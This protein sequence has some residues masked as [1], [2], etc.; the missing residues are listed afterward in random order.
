MSSGG[1]VECTGWS[2]GV[3]HCISSDEE[4]AATSGGSEDE[5]DELSGS[6]LEE[7]I[8]Q[9]R[10]RSV[11]GMAAGQPALDTA[12]PS[13]TAE[14]PAAKHDRFPIIMASRSNQE[15]TKAESTWSLGYNGQAP[16]M[17]RHREKAARDKEAENAKLRKG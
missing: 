15:W 17:K 3:A 11:R 8:Q 9:N 13:L 7:V 4:L 14:N 6:E 16:Q 5:V 1:E 2:G 12:E 10:E